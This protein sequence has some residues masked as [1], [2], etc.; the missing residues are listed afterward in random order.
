MLYLFT[1]LDSAWLSL[2][3]LDSAWLSLEVGTK[4]NKQTLKVQSH[5]VWTLEKGSKYK[6]YCN[7]LK[8]FFFALG[9]QKSGRLFRTIFA[10]EYKK[11]NKTFFSHKIYCRKIH[12]TNRLD[13]KMSWSLSTSQRNWQ[14]RLHNFWQAWDKWPGTILV[15]TR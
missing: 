15:S 14:Y 3:Q 10:K 5:L 9:Q 1:Q 4:W 6:V 11:W 7:T 2:T 8:P 12:I 13:M